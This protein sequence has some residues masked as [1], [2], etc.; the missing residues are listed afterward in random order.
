MPKALKNFGTTTY[1]LLG[2]IAPSFP[3]LKF[4][5]HVHRLTMHYIP[6]AILRTQ[7]LKC[8]KFDL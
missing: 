8:M 5:N 7:N 3:Y 6:W 4:N 1:L 2:F